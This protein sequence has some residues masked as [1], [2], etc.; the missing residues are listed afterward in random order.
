MLKCKKAPCVDWF[1]AFP[2]FPLQ[3]TTLSRNPDG[4]C[5]M[6]TLCSTVVNDLH[7]FNCHITLWGQGSYHPNL[8]DGETHT[9]SSSD[10]PMASQQ[11]SNKASIWRAWLWA[12]AWIQSLCPTLRNTTPASWEFPAV[13]WTSGEA[14]NRVPCVTSTCL[15]EEGIV[16]WL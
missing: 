4:H 13:T 6:H 3:E 2:A 7:A 14:W 10:L 9:G 15:M 5:W 8:T 16:I 12:A 11:A 1:S